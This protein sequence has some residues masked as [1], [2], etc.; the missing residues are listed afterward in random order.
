MS[1]DTGQ[2]LNCDSSGIDIGQVRATS[3]DSDKV[4]SQIKHETR[5]EQG[6]RSESSVSGNRL[7]SSPLCVYTQ[8]DINALLTLN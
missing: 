3:G 8:D 5:Q 1:C 7:V 6:M 4:T 2:R